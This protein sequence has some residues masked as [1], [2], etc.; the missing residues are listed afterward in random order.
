[1]H[2]QTNHRHQVESDLQRV[3]DSDHLE[4]SSLFE[5]LHPISHDGLGDLELVCNRAERP[6]TFGLQRG[7]DTSI[8]LIERCNIA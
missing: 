8:D 6:A 1:M 5:P 2:S 4:N 3:S 7:D